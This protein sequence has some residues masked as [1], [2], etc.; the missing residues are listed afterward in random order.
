VGNFI[1]GSAD[2]ANATKVYLSNLTGLSKVKSPKNL[3]QINFKID[4]NS[5]YYK[6]LV[7]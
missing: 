5:E 6:N 2:F 4:R 3:P 7:N 1:K